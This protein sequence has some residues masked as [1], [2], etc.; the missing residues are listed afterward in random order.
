MNYKINVRQ[1]QPER[2]S[3]LLQKIYI[4]KMCRSW[5]RDR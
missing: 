5:D 3:A 2:T 1:W 4:T